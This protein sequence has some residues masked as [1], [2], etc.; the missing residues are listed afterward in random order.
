MNESKISVRYA[1]ALYALG[2]EEKITEFLRLDMELFLECENSM[3]DF[4]NFL[5][6]PVVR[7]SKKQ[8][9]LREIFEGKVNPTTISFFNLV[10]KNNREQ[11][12]PSIARYFIELFKLDQG[13]KMATITTSKPLDDEV[14]DMVAKII[15][16]RFKTKLELKDF[17]D[18][19]LIGGFVLRIED[20]Q[21]DASISSSLNKIKR[22]LLSA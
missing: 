14:K 10:L 21:I 4:R 12:L 16:K 9:I 13:I 8:K 18:E 11:Y 2:K 6:N 22:E 20:L 5:N 3:E 19:S 1:K 7:P 15:A 17:T